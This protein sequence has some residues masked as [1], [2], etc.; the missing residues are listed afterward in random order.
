MGSSSC[1][2]CKSSSEELM[3]GY[4][5]S[6]ILKNKCTCGSNVDIIFCDRFFCRECFSK[7][8]CKCGNAPDNVS[9]GQPICNSCYH[10]NSM[11]LEYPK[12]PLF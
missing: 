11:I 10:L 2:I 6:C 7:I 12:Y 5:K 8:K 3:A 1:K 9:F 4:C